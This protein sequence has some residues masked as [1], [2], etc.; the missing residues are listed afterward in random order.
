VKSNAKTSCAGLKITGKRSTINENG[1]KDI[2]RS[3]GHCNEVVN[4]A[5]VW[6][7]FCPN[8]GYLLAS[9]TSS[10]RKYRTLVRAGPHNEKRDFRE[11]RAAC[12]P[13]EPYQR[14]QGPVG[15]E[16][17]LG[18]IRDSLEIRSRP[19]RLKVVRRS[20]SCHITPPSS[21]TQR[22]VTHP[23]IPRSQEPMSASS[24]GGCT[25][26]ESPC[27]HRAPLP[28][29]FWGDS[30]DDEVG[31]T[32]SNASP[33]RRVVNKATDVFKSF[34]TTKRFILQSPSRWRTTSEDS[35][36]PTSEPSSK[37]SNPARRA[38]SMIRDLRDN[39]KKTSEEGAFY[40]SVANRAR[41]DSMIKFKRLR[42]K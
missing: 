38:L 41:V 12:P 30:S 23:G 2:V 31:P 10:L 20:P 24:A 13:R 36:D 4:Y 29:S 26:S 8:C 33:T 25:I 16:Y 40:P 39:L 15:P 17:M 42:G 28:D 21:I 35:S 9:T 18:D 22:H 14:Q 7:R 34:S 27:E 5:N 37:G 6:N 3:C 1:D 19:L 32:S 11:I